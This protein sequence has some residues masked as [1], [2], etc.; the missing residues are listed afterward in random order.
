MKHISRKEL[1]G[2]NLDDDCKKANIAKNEYGKFD[3]RCF[4]YGL[5]D[6]STESYLEKCIGCGAFVDNAKPLK[7]YPRDEKE[8]FMEMNAGILKEICERLRRTV[9]E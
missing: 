1:R 9:N 5:I 4:C 3:N 7:V 8:L 2:K 6:D